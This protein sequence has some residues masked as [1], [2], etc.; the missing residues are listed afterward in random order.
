ML[1]TE[2]GAAEND[3]TDENGI[4]WMTAEQWRELHDYLVEFGGIPA[5]LDDVSVTYD[6]QFI[7]QA[8][9]DGE[10]DWP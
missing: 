4:G 9:K 5:P 7:Q 3:L 1:D 6:D 10:M 2:L 8:Y